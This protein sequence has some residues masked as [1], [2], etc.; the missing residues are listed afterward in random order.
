MTAAIET[1]TR[2]ILGRLEREGWRKVGGP[3]HDEFQH[4]DKPSVVITVPR[5]RRLSIGTARAIAKAAGWI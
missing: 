5:H 2:K 4:P 3:R 1:S